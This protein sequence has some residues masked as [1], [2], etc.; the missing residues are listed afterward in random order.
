MRRVD[1]IEDEQDPESAGVSADILIFEL[2]EQRFGLPASH[3]RELLR[4]V[5]VTPLPNA[6]WFVDGIINVR[7]ELMPVLDLASRLRLPTKPISHTDHLIVVSVGDRLVALRAQRA[8]DLVRLDV[9]Q[10]EPLAQHLGG[11]GT[12]A[13]VAMLA[14]GL[15]LVPDPEQLFSDAESKAV[16]EALAR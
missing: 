3:V 6:P 11:L 14:D 8:T 16:D 2:G 15:I 13:S 9:R 10:I 12:P 5:A 4:A 1:S 7:G